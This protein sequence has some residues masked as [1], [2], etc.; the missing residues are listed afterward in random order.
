MVI[1]GDAQ[2]LEQVREDRQHLTEVVRMYLREKFPEN[3]LADGGVGSSIE[4]PNGR[5]I[6]V[7]T[8]AL[9][10]GIGFRKYRY[11]WDPS[12]VWARPSRWVYFT[13]PN[14]ERSFLIRLNEAL[15]KTIE[16]LETW[17]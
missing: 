3:V 5:M 2:R 7:T 15:E 9:G 12:K 10:D 8:A 17:T 11:H 6:G 13:D 4:F 1:V 14:D 16:E